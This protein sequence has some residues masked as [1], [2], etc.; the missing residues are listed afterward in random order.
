MRRC[1]RVS[2]CFLLG[3][4]GLTVQ[5]R[6]ALADSWEI[7]NQFR[8]TNSVSVAGTL[9]ESH[10]DSD[11]AAASD[12]GLFESQT[13]ALASHV[14]PSST[15]IVEAEAVTI[16]NQCSILATNRITVGG[17]VGASASAMGTV[18]MAESD[19]LSD[20]SVVLILDEPGTVELTG[21]AESSNFGQVSVTLNGPN[22]FSYDKFVQGSSD[23][24]HFDEQFLVEAGTYTFRVNSV[25]DAEAFD[26]NSGG[27]GASWDLELRLL[28]CTDPGDPVL[29]TAYYAVDRESNT[30]HRNFD[31]T[32]GGSW[33]SP[34]SFDIGAS[35][36][37]LTVHPESNEIYVIDEGGGTEFLGTID[38]N[39]GAVTS[40]T[41]IA[42]SDPLALPGLEDIAFDENGNLYCIYEWLVP[43]IGF[44]GTVD[45]NS[46]LVTPTG[47]GQISFS[48][49]NARMAFDP[50]S[51]L[52]YFSTG[53][54]L[55]TVDVNSGD[56]TPVSLNAPPEFSALSFHPSGSPFMACSTS[57]ALFE[58]HPDTGVVAP[59]PGA[60][61]PPTV[62]SGF[63][64]VTTIIGGGDPVC[65]PLDGD[66]GDVT[67]DNL[68]TSADIAE[69]VDCITGPGGGIPAISS[70]VHADMQQDGDVDLADFAS[71]AIELAAP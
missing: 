59:L 25:A 1:D 4:F 13:E 24:F 37:A 16:A 5:A 21:Y 3:V 70:C 45:V 34:G 56:I 10:T 27:Q 28:E 69:Y 11:E 29:Q 7:A 15:P 53:T 30:V 63:D 18:S 6:D 9:K 44:F 43:G 64:Q 36:H 23:E 19:A 39:T 48:G 41:A 57:A 47:W 12:F 35:G 14:D 71:F 33:D 60:L 66:L 46:G 38:P 62:L 17:R 40:L 20:F 68:V 49:T 51:G 2:K 55:G 52:L 42:N 65:T 58:I 67:D 22:F 61:L 32:G 54:S 31:L 26:G 8:S 50:V